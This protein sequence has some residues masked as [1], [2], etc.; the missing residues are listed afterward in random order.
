MLCRSFSTLKFPFLDFLSRP[1]KP[2]LNSLPVLSSQLPTP[3]GRQTVQSASCCQLL[4][5]LVPMAFSKH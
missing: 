2:A 1:V 5:N 3:Q 4:V